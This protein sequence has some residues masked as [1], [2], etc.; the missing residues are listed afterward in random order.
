VALVG[1]F[2]P[3][4]KKEAELVVQAIEDIGNKDRHSKTIQLLKYEV[5][6]RAEAKGKKFFKKL[7]KFVENAV[8]A[9]L[10]L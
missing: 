3:T 2:K 9:R 5:K 7:G 4:Y 8:K 10:G 1:I 6:S